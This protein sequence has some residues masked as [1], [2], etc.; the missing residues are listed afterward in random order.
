MEKNE[1]L[2]IVSDQ[3]LELNNDDALT[4]QLYQVRA[5]AIQSEL[6]DEQPK[7]NFQFNEK[8]ITKISDF[9]FSESSLLIKEQI[10]DKSNL[11]L[12]IRKAADT[13]EFLS[14]FSS[15]EEKEFLLIKS[16][17]CNQIAGYQA[18]AY[19]LANLL[20][21]KYLPKLQFDPISEDLP[22]LHFRHALI[23]FIRRDTRKLRTI[24]TKSLSAISELQPIIVTNLSEGS[25]TILDIYSHAG[26]AFF[27]TAM[28]SFV[29]YCL[30][31]N[32]DE[33]ISTRNNLEKSYLNFKQAKEV[34]F[35]TIVYE[36]NTTLELFLERNT[37]S[38]IQANSI[39]SYEK[40]IFKAYLRNL[41]NQH[42]IVEFWQSQLKAIQSG[43]L[44]EEKSFVIQMPT[45]SGKTLIAELGILT[46]LSN[47][48]SKRCLYIAPFRALVNQVER[49][50]SKTL[51][52]LGIRV[53]TI[54]GGFEF[55]A[56][57]DFLLQESQVLIATPEKV[58][59]FL[60]THPEYFE[61]VSLVVIDEGH[62]VDDGIETE[63]STTVQN[64]LKDQNS[65]GRGALLELL[66]TRLK[67]KLPNAKFLFLSAVMPEVN[68]KDFL[69]WL[70]TQEDNLLTINPSERPSR[71]TIAKFDWI[72]DE[73][74]E[75]DYISLPVFPNGRHPFVP[76]FV[77]R[78]RA[79]YLSGERTPTGKPKRT[80]WPPSLL[81]RTQ[82]TAMVACKFAKSG[83]VLVFCAT[84]NDVLNVTKNILKLLEILELNNELP[85]NALSY[86][87]N[88][89]L[90]SF[91]MSK[92]WFGEDNL[93]TSALHRG[94]AY[95]FGPLP[96]QV[97]LSIE[98]EFRKNKIRILVCTNTLAQGVNLPI[99]TAII[100][101]LEHML[102]GP[103]EDGSQKIYKVKKRD[104]WN[105]C[106]RAGRAGKETEGQ[107][108]FMNITD[109]DKH[110]IDEYLNIN[111]ME[112][113]NSALFKLLLELVN[114]RI[115]EEELFEY[116]DVHVLAMMSEEI[117][118]TDDDTV[119]VNFLKTSL[120]GVQAA[121]NGIDIEP[122]VNTFRKTSLWIKESIEDKS[123]QQV[124]STTGLRLSSCISLN[125]FAEDFCKG[126]TEETLAT[127]ASESSCNFELLE[128]AFQAC[129]ELPEM[130]FKTRT[131]IS[132]QGPEDEYQIISAWVSGKSIDE[133]KIQH[134][135]NGDIEALS[136]YLADRVI[137][138]LP[139]GIHAFLIIV[140]NILKRKFEDL[141]ILWQNTP[142]MVKF[143]VSSLTSAW[144]GS[145]GIS[146]RD[147]CIQISEK[148]QGGPISFPSFIK[149]IANLSSDFV[150]N[151]L[152][153]TEMQKQR[154]IAEASKIIP[155]NETLDFYTNSKKELVT[156]IR[157]IRF[158]DRHN[159]ASQIKKD[160]KLVL[161]LEPDNPIDSTAIKVLFNNQMVGYIPRDKTKLVSQEIEVGNIAEALAYSITPPSDKY[162]YPNIEVLIKF[163]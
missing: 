153:G 49:D 77:Q 65:I 114:K 46:R 88:P 128:V 138:K 118:D 91:E 155:D 1:Y 61:K 137:Y 160:D 161:E 96:Q 149:W 145:I 39:K 32:K 112:E 98:D 28:K 70:N 163:I 21:R 73:N 115:S 16:A 117:I 13:F 4:R 106:G 10:G 119:I 130:R 125:K 62:I 2:N 131:G 124:F 56:F 8:Q 64:Q 40:P 52:A 60:R 11:L 66:I 26:F 146:S 97:R 20:E 157:G 127:Q 135:N 154:L 147:F 72:T 122:L 30:S 54:L 17:L 100:Y 18:N 6:L 152:K 55:D 58:D 22:V 71:Q 41:A 81:S 95:H 158:N 63:S 53:S 136:E 148:Y 104:F 84:R 142:S 31:G 126:I 129:K 33:F 44:D 90:E 68:S 110:V 93:L 34:T 120:V 5:K 141:P 150:E 101:S 45:S 23:N 85:H 48:P 151:E 140:A 109:N 144:A 116:L 9:L 121:R 132:Y 79:Q 103:Q 162:P 159:I 35:S 7:I 107:I 57:E 27:E 80:T 133:L 75:L 143:G 43:I 51:G 74:G 15:D 38:T 113:V 134:W 50:L 83:S 42:S 12:A 59:I 111:N 29:N 25:A 139:W 89:N 86:S 69:N 156:T 47:D 105:I 87:K 14:K 78:K 82:S 76:F 94:I 24:S 19:C 67:H 108:I 123:L 3:L 102:E 37:W 36:I 99:K 92:E